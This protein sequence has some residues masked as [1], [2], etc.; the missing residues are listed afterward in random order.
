MMRVL[1]SN[2]EWDDLVSAGT[3]GLIDA[4]ES[5]DP[6]RGLAFS[7]FAA[8]RIRGAILDEL[9]R[10]DALPRSVRRKQRAIA[11]AEHDLAA[12][13]E[14][15]PTA[16]ETAGQLGI[17]VEQLHDWRRVADDRQHFSLDDIV[18]PGVSAGDS[19]PGITAEDIDDRVLTRQRAD[20]L[21]REIGRLSERDRMV[22]TLYYFHELKLREIGEVLGL[23]E[24]RVSQIRTRALDTLKE[25]V[26]HIAEEYA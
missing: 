20:I 22:L 1:S 12:R 19:L 3:M 4:V 25:R 21:Q 8:P 16:R 26:Q 2:A 6:A 13:L 9:R 24:S 10:V 5:F 15:T 23:T 17:E 18:R 7:T 11:G 14:R